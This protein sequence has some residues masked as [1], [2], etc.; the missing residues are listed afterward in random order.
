MILYTIAWLFWAY[1]VLTGD[2]F[3]LLISTVFL[4]FIAWCL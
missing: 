4:L 3:D 2:G 1:Y